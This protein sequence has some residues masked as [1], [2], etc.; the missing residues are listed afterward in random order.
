MG[1]LNCSAC[2]LALEPAEVR[3][4]K[5]I[6][7]AEA[8]TI[9]GALFLGGTW[10][11]YEWGSPIAIEAGDVFNRIFSAAI[12]V[13]I[14]CNLF[15]AL[16]SCILWITAIVYGSRGDFVYNARDLIQFCNHLMWMTYFSVTFGCGL[17]LYLNLRSNLIDLL[18]ILIFVGIVII[19]GMSI[20]CELQLSV[21]PLATYHQPSWIK[22]FTH[23]R[24]IL[25][26]KTR[27]ELRGKAVVESEYIQ[28]KANFRQIKKEL[29]STPDSGICILLRTA[30]KNLNRP[31]YDISKFETNLAEDWFNE[32][33]ELKH[34]SVECL[35]KYMP[36]RLAEEVHKLVGDI[37]V[38]VSVRGIS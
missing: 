28:F 12:S 2:A 4:E 19:R 3:T 32:V 1:R 26:S 6:M 38:G 18:V 13:V 17:A 37:E 21:S 31:D 36:M 11:I 35:A 34:R 27:E 29:D 30:A 33:E 8:Y 20:M 9:F 22:L 24:F 25:S 7:L 14:C 16:W 15:L 5:V 10:V 23:P